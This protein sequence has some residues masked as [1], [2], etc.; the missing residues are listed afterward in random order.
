MEGF[1]TKESTVPSF[2]LTTRASEGGVGAL[3][4][5][6]GVGSIS[7]LGCEGDK[8]DVDDGYALV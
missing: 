2:S 6:T 5:L 7:W 1:G 8:M 4:K 3:V